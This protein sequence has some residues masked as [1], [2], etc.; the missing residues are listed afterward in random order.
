MEFKIGMKI[1]AHVGF[2][3]MKY[4]YTGSKRVNNATTITPFTHHH[5]R[6]WQLEKK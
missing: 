6:I 4:S 2:L 1:A 5:T 3:G